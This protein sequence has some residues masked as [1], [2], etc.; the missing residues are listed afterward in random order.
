MRVDKL[1]IGYNDGKK[2]ATHQKN[3]Q[4]Y[5]FNYN[6]IIDK[7]LQLDKYLVLGKKGTGKTL[8]GEVIK[9]RAST[10]GDW[11]CDLVSYKNFEFKKL[12]T[13]R[14]D[15]TKPNEYSAIWKWLILIKI[16][17]MCRDDQTADFEATERIKKFISSNFNG[18]KL[19]M[20]KIVKET[21]K[22]K[23]KGGFLSSYFNASKSKESSKEVIKG[24]YLDYLEDLE[25]NIIQALNNSKTRYT[26]I[27]DELDD[28]F[29]DDDLYKS[30]IISLIKTIDELNLEFQEY[31]INIK[32]MVLLRSDIFYILNDADL[33][34]IECDN[35]LKIS[36][37]T[38][39]DKNSPLIKMVLQKIQQSII[40]GPDDNKENMSLEDL[41]SKLFPATF[42]SKRKWK[43]FN[44]D[45]AD[46]I[47]QR[48]FLRPRDL[49]TYLKCAVDINPA[50]EVFTEKMIKGANKAYSDYLLKEIR[51][52]MH[53]H[54]EENE[55]NEMFSLLRR[56]KRKN[57]QYQD[58][59]KF[60]DNNRGL[61]PNIKLN[62]TLKLLFDFGVIG[63]V[64]QYNGRARFSW[65]FRENTSIDY[66]KNFIIHMGLREELNIF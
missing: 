33:N 27:L 65:A 22:R 16:A 43:H 23:I 12:T 55:I 61:Y 30:N 6:G 64:W 53:G 15:D 20:D 63:N 41:Y 52:E 40:Q 11:I 4:D 34:K 66:N 47:L 48:T 17:E 54:I 39:S 19:D 18:L 7:A 5:Y 9:Q 56:F 28:R 25:E 60:F 8:L 42:Y 58:I 57:F 59:E 21:L 1:F 46:Y 35:A 50:S 45:S 32:V 10:K 62:E 44:R 37:G 49:I 36:W 31:E 29:K 51:N 14:T 3:F 38:S 24:D 2:E 26:L 13:L